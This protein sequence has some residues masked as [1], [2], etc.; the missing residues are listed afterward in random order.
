MHTLKVQEGV[1]GTQLVTSQ[2]TMAGKACAH[3]GGSPSH[4]AEIAGSLICM[5]GRATT[6]QDLS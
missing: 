2:G 6:Q 1:T 3:K 4:Q 5:E